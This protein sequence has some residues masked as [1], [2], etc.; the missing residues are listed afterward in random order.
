MN[1]LPSSDL[2]K[3]LQ[4]PDVAEF[5]K[6]LAAVEPGLY[7]KPELGHRVAGADR[8]DRSVFYH[9]V[10]ALVA[11]GY[12]DQQIAI[13]NQGPLHI[14]RIDRDDKLRDLFAEIQ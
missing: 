7:S 10:N 14:I 11:T 5:A 8:I 6:K 13:H 1:T 2:D 12:L 3:L 4:R 9:L